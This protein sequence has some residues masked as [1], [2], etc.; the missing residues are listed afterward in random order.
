MDLAE[1]LIDV[2]YYNT[3]LRGPESI[4]NPLGIEHAGLR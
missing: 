2:I 3:A 1:K 4:Q